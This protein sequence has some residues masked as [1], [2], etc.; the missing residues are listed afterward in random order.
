MDEDL[1]AALGDDPIQAL[2]SK[3]APPGQSAEVSA[4]EF[5]DAGWR[6]PLF[7]ATYAAARKRGAKDWFK[8]IA[9]ASDVVGADHEV[10]VHHIFPKAQLKKIG[11]SRKDRDEI[12]NLAFLAARPNRQISARPPGEYLKEIAE[13]HPDASRPSACRWT[14]ACGGWIGF[15]IFSPS[16]GDCWPKPSMI[17][18]VGLCDVA[19]ARGEC[20]E[21]ARPKQSG[22]TIVND[23]KVDHSILRISHGARD[24]SRLS[25]ME[26]EVR[27]ERRA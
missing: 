1:V 19:P 7:P 20:R 15:R 23:A 5:D 9:L 13:I 8:G 11:V 25:A 18:C 3:A 24:S 10:Q 6:N 27:P 2:M 16:D 26:R 17:W 12:A 14:E 22:S 4:E 21:P